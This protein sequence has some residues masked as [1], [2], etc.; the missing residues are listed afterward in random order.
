MFNYSNTGFNTLGFTNNNSTLG[1]FKSP[2]QLRNDLFENKLKN[3]NYNI[4]NDLT[5]ITEHYIKNVSSKNLNEEYY[6][7]DYL[8]NILSKI[9]KYKCKYG[10][11][12]IYNFLEYLKLVI[13]IFNKNFELY[14]E[15]ITNIEIINNLQSLGQNQDSFKSFKVF[16]D[17][18]LSLNTE[19]KLQDYVLEYLK[20]NNKSINDLFTDKL[21]LNEVLYQIRN[22]N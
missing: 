16:Q 2:C 3:I 1:F 15:N 7:S 19:I 18:E 9:N 13:F 5:L 17:K 10:S 21:L 8:N 20:I 4:V 11:K 14:K 6:T 22:N 12:Q